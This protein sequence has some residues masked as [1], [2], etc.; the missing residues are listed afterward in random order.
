[1]ADGPTIQE[2]NNKAL[3]NGMSLSEL[4][5]QL[6]GMR[7]EI[8]LPVILMGYINP[9]LQYGLEHFCEDCRKVGVDGVIIPDLPM[10]EYLES[11]K[12]LFDAHGLYNI[13]LITPQTSEERIREID[14]NTEGFIYMVSTSGT[15]GA[16][17]GI[18]A[19]QIG[20]FKKI[21]S[22]KLQNPVL[23]G[24]GISN[25][26]S[27]QDACNYANGAIIGSAFIKRLAESDDLEY[28][29]TS[30]IREIKGTEL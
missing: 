16:R 3:D 25:R 22:M 30:Y 28:G 18:S 12:A 29:I 9:V 13:F 5:R 15:T 2:S 26:Q 23:I 1:V 19:D 27:F 11:Y 17:A 4:F 8:S 7:E 21:A 6:E 14:Q 10:Q 24:F 20:Y